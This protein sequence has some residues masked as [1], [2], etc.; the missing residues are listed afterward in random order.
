[1][2]E[3]IKERVKKERECLGGISRLLIFKE[4]SNFDFQDISNLG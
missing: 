4:K 1:M 2:F 3:V